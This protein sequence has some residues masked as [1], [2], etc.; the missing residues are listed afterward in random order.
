MTTPDRALTG[1][2]AAKD[3][4]GLGLGVWSIRD[5][6]CAMKSFLAPPTVH[7][8]KVPISWPEEEPKPRI[9]SPRLYGVLSGDPGGLVDHWDSTFACL[10]V[11]KSTYVSQRSEQV[12]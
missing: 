9:K 11:D 8:M 6:W 2:S 3:M 4:Q 5:L 1:H 12:S 10:A 7:C